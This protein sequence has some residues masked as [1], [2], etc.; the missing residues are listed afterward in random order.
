MHDIKYCNLL[1]NQYKQVQYIK[2]IVIEL[3]VEVL[4]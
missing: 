4:F 3:L 2:L 1:C